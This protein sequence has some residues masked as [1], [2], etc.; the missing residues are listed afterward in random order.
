MVPA[1]AELG[2]SGEVGRLLDD[3]DAGGE[4]GPALVQ[5]R[6]AAGCETGRDYHVDGVGLIA[7]S[8]AAGGDSQE[9]VVDDVDEVARGEKHEEFR[10]LKAYWKTRLEGRK[11][12]IVRFRNG[13]AKDAPEMDVEFL[14]VDKRRKCYA[15][16]LGKI[17][18]LKR[19]PG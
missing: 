6:N 7:V 11:Y 8:E 14:G 19:W 4:Y 15:I 3:G 2:A 18:S 17:L 13:Y 5:E 10:D 16:R 9:V 1:C 12:D